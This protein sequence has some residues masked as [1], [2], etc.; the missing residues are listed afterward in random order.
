[1]TSHGYDQYEVS[2]FAKSG[3]ASVHNI[4]YWKGGEYIGLG[5]GAVTTTKGIRRK[6]T[7]CIEKY[8]EMSEKGFKPVVE[9]EALGERELLYERIM[10]SLRMSRGIELSE[11][12]RMANNK[13]NIILDNFINVLLDL[14]YAKKQSGYFSLTPSGFFRS[15]YIISKL[16][17]FYDCCIEEAERDI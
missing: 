8:I 6:N 14:G 3:F 16:L 4:N 9:T 10:L 13:N 2:N 5:L 1:L 17:T 15:N 12:E 11:L 7:D